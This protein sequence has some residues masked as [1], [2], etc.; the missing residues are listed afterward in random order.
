MN[1]K[2]TV[3]RSIAI[4][5]ILVISILSGFLYS[6]VWNRIDR[7]RYP[8]QYSE[9]VGKYASEYGVPEYIVYAVMKTESNFESN[10]VSPAGAVGL[11]QLTPDTFDW[12]SMLMKRSTETGMLYDPE[13]SI[14]Y[15]TYLLSYLYMHYN[16][17]DTV[18]AAYN[19][20]MARVDEWLADPSL[21]DENGRLESIPFEE[22]EE[23]VKKVNNAIDVYRR[24]YY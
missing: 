5:I 18:F 16:R 6:A 11:M 13:T 9:Y 21:T 14:E 22:T 20:G 3:R 2:K 7:S 24:L 10:A 15:G 4:L 1:W 23:Y 8:Q 17:W 19:A 12:V